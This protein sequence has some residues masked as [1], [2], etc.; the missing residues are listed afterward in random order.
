MTDVRAFAIAISFLSSRCAGLRGFSKLFRR[1][2]GRGRGAPSAGRQIGQHLR[3]HQQRDPCADD[4]EE[5]AAREQH[6]AVA[7]A[8]P[9]LR[10]L[11]GELRVDHL[12]EL[13]WRCVGGFVFFQGL[14]KS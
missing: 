6:R 2:R 1:R 10:P 14:Q 13:F 9:A 11:H 7:P 5:D 12:Q 8:G 4:D 3:K